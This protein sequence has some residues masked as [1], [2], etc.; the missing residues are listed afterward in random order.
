MEQQTHFFFALQI[1][2]ETKL[3]MKMIMNELKADFTFARWVNHQDLHITLAFLGHAP[4]DKLQEAETKVAEALRNAISFKLEIDK[5]GFFGRADSPRVFWADTIESEQLIDI[6][7]KVFSACE[8]AGF[9]LEARPFRPHITLARKWAGEMPF[10][11]NLLDNWKK[12][13]PEPLEFL[14]SNVVLYQT[15]LHKIPKYEAKTIFRLL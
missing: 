11:Q 14:A 2:D 10:D 8:S 3:K 12:I 4:A 5:I 1:S 9:L 7:K 6:R 15:H 13:Q